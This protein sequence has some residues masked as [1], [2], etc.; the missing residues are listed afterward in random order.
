MQAPFKHFLSIVFCFSLISTSFGQGQ[1]FSKNANY[2]SL[3]IMITG[4]LMQTSGQIT[5]AYDEKRNKYFYDHN[6]HYVQ[7]I[8]GLGDIVI[9][10]LETTFSGKP[11]S[12]MPS[13]SAPDEFAYA[14]KFSGFNFLVTANEHCNDRGFEG[15]YRTNR[16]LD[17]MGLG[18][19]GTFNDPA[20]RDRLYPA[21]LERNGFRIAILNYSYGVIASASPPAVV[22]LINK[23]KIIADLQRA[24]FMKPDYTIVYFHWGTE[25]Q[26]FPNLDQKE[27]AKLCFDNGADLVVG[28]NP[29]VLQR[30][31][32]LEYF[33]KG[34]ARRGLVAYSLGNFVSDYNRRYGDGSA[35][36]EVVLGKEKKS[37]KTKLADY[38][39]VPTYIVKEDAAG[40][41]KIEVVPVAEIERARVSVSLTAK[42]LENLKISGQDSRM[43]LT[44]AN[45]VEAQYPLNDDIVSDVAET[46]MLTGAPMNRDKVSPYVKLIPVEIPWTHSID[47]L[48]AINKVYLSNIK[49][50]F[51]DRKFDPKRQIVNHMEYRPAPKDTALLARDNSPSKAGADRMQEAPSGRSSSIKPDTQL[52]VKPAPVKKDTLLAVKPPLIKKD[53]LQKPKAPVVKRDTIP[54][55]PPVAAQVYAKDTVKPIPG[56]PYG[57]NGAD[58]QVAQIQERYRGAVISFRVRFYEMKTRLEINT[59][60]YRYLEGYE[61]VLI[62]GFWTYYLGNTQDFTEAKDLCLL[63]RSK[64]LKKVVIIPFMN[65]KKLDW[66]LNF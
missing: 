56:L 27:L 61:S 44:S 10:N 47:T 31:E 59:Y 9:G 15:I 33:S 46:I 26:R 64:G 16:L 51:A 19:T 22:N 2:D 36:F 54:G 66:K 18:H 32:E 62:D 48:L 1:S 49:V 3:R 58:D 45:C 57:Y 50:S 13:Y 11:Y 43:M 40:G 53:T 63:L 24:R 4:D 17:S 8:L 12:G 37:G 29:H 34:E 6:F 42:E 38:G 20:D 28:S 52:V 14:L 30:V 25:Y 23:P 7:P 60:Y 21:I 39:F 65:G 35:I 5:T 55:P 41:K